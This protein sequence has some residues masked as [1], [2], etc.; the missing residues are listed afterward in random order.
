MKR[1]MERTAA[2]MELPGKYCTWTSVSH[3]SG[4]L[5]TRHTAKMQRCDKRVI[6]MLAIPG[7]LEGFRRHPGRII[8]WTDMKKNLKI[9]RE[10][11][12][13]LDDSHRGGLC[14]C[15]GFCT[16]RL[17]LVGVLL[18]LL[19]PSWATVCLN[20]SVRERLCQFCDSGFRQ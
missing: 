12:A 3:P 6:N 14:A 1:N 5:V 9:A 18:C 11:C 16:V 13:R 4:I 10:H 20:H 7:N 2:Y 8:L 19:A 17:R 15:G